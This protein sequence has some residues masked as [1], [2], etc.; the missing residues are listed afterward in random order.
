MRLPW[1]ASLG[2]SS[3]LGFLVFGS[4]I[5]SDHPVFP[6]WC[7]GRS[8]SSSASCEAAQPVGVQGAR[9]QLLQGR[10]QS[11]NEAF[12]CWIRSPVSKNSL[13]LWCFRN[14]WIMVA[15]EKI[16][17]WYSMIWDH[18]SWRDDYSEDTW[19]NIEI[20]AFETPSLASSQSWLKIQPQVCAHP[21]PLHLMWAK[22]AARCHL[23]VDTIWWR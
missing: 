10:L 2:F 18:V 8:G 23:A 16:E 14:L 19:I 13:R 6:A 7:A 22:V 9:E 3:V 12:Y 1:F 11:C 21:H 15:V 5:I 17:S 20:F 4:R